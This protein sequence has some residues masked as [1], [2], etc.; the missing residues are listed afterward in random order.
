MGNQYYSTGKS[1]KQRNKHPSV[2]CY[3]T[4]EAAVLDVPRY[5][6]HLKDGFLTA[7]FISIKGSHVLPLVDDEI[8]INLHQALSP[9]THAIEEASFNLF[10]L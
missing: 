7:S 2:S 6:Q 10:C 8:T 4:Y 3:C 9:V 5:C 1:G